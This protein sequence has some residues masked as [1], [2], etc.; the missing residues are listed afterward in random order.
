MK[1]A[2]ET[3]PKPAD[4]VAAAI[5]ASKA[6]P[7]TLTDAQ[8]LELFQA[9]QRFDIANNNATPDAIGVVMVQVMHER[10]QGLKTAQAR[11]DALGKTL[12]RAGYSLDAR[13]GVYTKTP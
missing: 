10:I 9:A 7:P 12:G 13:T 11:L 5:A 2:R 8:K 4:A 6:A 1:K 3:K